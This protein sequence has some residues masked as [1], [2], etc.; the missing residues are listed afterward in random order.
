MKNLFKYFCTIFLVFFHENLNSEENIYLIK[1]NEISIEIS[2]IQ[3]AR[4]QAKDIAFYNAYSKLIEKIIPVS[5]QNKNLSLELDDIRNLVSD[6]TFK[7]EDFF[8][9]NYSAKIDVNFNP[10]KVGELLNKFDISLSN[11]I[12]EEFLVLPVHNNH[13]TYYLWEKNNKWYHELKKNYQQNGL[14]KLF[15]PE[16]VIKNKFNMTVENAIQFD[17][18]SYKKILNDYKKNSII[19]I[20]FEENYDY[21]IESFISKVNFKVYSQNK[22]ENI[23][24]NNRLL[25]LDYSKNTQIE[26]FAKLSLKE[27]NDWW[28]SKINIS[29]KIE[30]IKKYVISN[31]FFNLKDS[32]KLES[33]LRKNSLVIDLVPRVISKNI[34]FYDLKSYGSVEKINLALRALN[35]Q[36]E[37]EPDSKIYSLTKINP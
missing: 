26:Y 29:N 20:F 28:K 10:Q 19:M 23:K 9:K 4:L 5:D 21:K 36:I 7:K 35:Y 8:Q 1:N 14:V 27:L 25:E 18:N 34:I 32:L 37:Y 24:I 3:K 13:N 11:V 17:E 22:F 12:S 16:L 33:I 15:F 31:E 2:D 30:N 6:F